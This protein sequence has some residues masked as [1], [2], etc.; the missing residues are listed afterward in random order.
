VYFRICADGTLRGPDNGIISRYLDG[1]WQ[2]ARGRHRAFDCSGPLFVRMT[3]SDGRRERIGPY[4]F[5]KVAGGAVFAAD[6]CV[7]VHDSR[8]ALESWAAA[9]EEIAFLSSAGEY[10]S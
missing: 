4:P 10:G 8:Q 2:L 6:S 9:C 5:V 3:N 1:Q 7:A